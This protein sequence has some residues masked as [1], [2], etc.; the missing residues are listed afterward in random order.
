MSAPSPYAEP[1]ILAIGSGLA[2]TWMRNNENNN[3][4][5]TTKNLVFNPLPHRKTTR[6]KLHLCCTS[7]SFSLCLS[8]ASA[9]QQLFSHLQALC[10]ARRVCDLL[11][12]EELEQHSQSWTHGSLGQQDSRHACHLAACR[13]KMPWPHVSLENA[14]NIGI[15]QLRQ[16]GQLL[17]KSS[18]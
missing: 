1:R 2:A 3:T 11:Q 12:L 6:S 4:A 9:S 15:L 10:G 18:R 13:L 14:G 16:G 5:T 17:M 8:P 7:I